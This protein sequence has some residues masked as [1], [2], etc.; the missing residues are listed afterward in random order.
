MAEDVKNRT[1]TTVT[2]DDD[3]KER[4]ILEGRAMGIGWTTALQILAREALAARDKRK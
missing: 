1:T 4:L 3:F 2:V